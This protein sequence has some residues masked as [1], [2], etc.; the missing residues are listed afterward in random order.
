[1]KITK[2]LLLL[3]LISAVSGHA[4]DHTSW[5]LGEDDAGAAADGTAAAVTVD[6]VG[7]KNLTLT[8]SG[9]YRS[10]V[11]SGGSALSLEFTGS[12]NYT[13]AGGG[14]FSGMDL[15][16]FQLSFDAVHSGFIQGLAGA[17]PELSPAEVKLSIFLKLGMNTKDIADLLYLTPESVRVARSRL[18]T[19]LGLAH[20]HNLHSYLMS[21]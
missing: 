12:G 5:R 16:D 7:A 13:G 21:F 15:N 18:R 6:A 19:K 11:P 14:F 20:A 3:T 10:D 8:G 1:M 4:A 9:T 17:H 2:T